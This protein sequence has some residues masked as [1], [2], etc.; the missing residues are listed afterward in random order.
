MRRV[1]SDGVTS[2]PMIRPV[3]VTLTC[4]FLV[5]CSRTETRNMPVVYF[6]ASWDIGEVKDC[7]L[8]PPNDSDVLSARFCSVT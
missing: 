1:H 3:F 7:E 6:S 8:Q 2:R 5:A 4:L